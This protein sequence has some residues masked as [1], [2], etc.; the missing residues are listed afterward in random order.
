VGPGQWFAAALSAD[1]A[2]GSYL[3]DATGKYQAFNG[4]SAATPYTAGIV[5]L[6]FEREPALT[7]GEIKRRLR[8]AARVDDHTG[9]P[10]TAKAGAGKLNME[11]VKLLFKSSDR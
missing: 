8:E 9:K 3:V 1:Q 10:P 4:T 7:S 6:L 11:A 5:A 2:S